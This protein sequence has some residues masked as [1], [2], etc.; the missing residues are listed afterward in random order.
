[1]CVQSTGP[2]ADIPIVSQFFPQSEDLEIQFQRSHAIYAIALDAIKNAGKRK[3]PDPIVGDQ[4]C[5]IRALKLVFILRSQAFHAEIRQLEPLTEEKIR[6]VKEAERLLHSIRKEKEAALRKPVS[7]IKAL[8]SKKRALAREI[9]SFP[10]Q[11]SGDNKV[12]ARDPASEIAEVEQQIEKIRQKIQPIES[13]YDAKVSEIK[14]SFVTDLAI[15]SDLAFYL[16]S[17][18]LTKAKSERTEIH[19]G[20]GEKIGHDDIDPASLKKI[21]ATLSTSDAKQIVKASQ[22]ALAALSVSFVQNEAKHCRSF[23][24]PLL[25]LMASKV[26]EVKHSGHGSHP[27]L[28]CYHYTRLIF[29]RALEERVP[30]ILKVRN[31]KEDPFDPS[32]FTSYTLFRV[33]HLTGS[34]AVSKYSQEDL[35]LPAIVMECRSQAAKDALSKASFIEELVGKTGGIVPLIELLTAQHVQYTDQKHMGSFEEYFSGID[36]PQSEKER[37]IKMGHLASALGIAPSNPT[38][39]CPEHIYCNTL[40]REM[41]KGATV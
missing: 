35:D 7:Q 28:P 14:A 41:P 12:E 8:A 17:E 22:K 2:V 4:A 34:Y 16:F 21:A 32:G 20:S 19:Q 1:M 18:I 39:C 27:E 24:Q 23:D 33:D 6:M 40:A 11:K 29:Q 30:I 9:P 5:Q 36:M 3:P 13:E 31:V 37:V 10:L 26:K 15:T 38:L 25:E